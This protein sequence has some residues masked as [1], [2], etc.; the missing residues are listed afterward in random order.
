MAI[1]LW[2]VYARIL[3]TIRF[4]TQRHVSGVRLGGGLA[5]GELPAAGS[6]PAHHRG[7][8]ASL[9]RRQVNFQQRNAKS[10]IILAKCLCRGTKRKRHSAEAILSLRCRK[11]RFRWNAARKSLIL[12]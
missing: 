11:D 12:R 8:P 10:H 3:P 2:Q 9:S 6:A 4:G 7:Q 1:S 5:R